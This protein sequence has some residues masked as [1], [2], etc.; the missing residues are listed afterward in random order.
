[1]LRLHLAYLFP[2]DIRRLLEVAGFR[3]ITIKGGFA[4]REFSQ[5]GQELVVEAL[6]DA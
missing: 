1:M 2:S 6:R 3:E 4:G 5:D